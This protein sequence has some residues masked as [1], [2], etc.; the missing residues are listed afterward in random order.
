MQKRDIP[1][2]FDVRPDLC[3]RGRI[4]VEWDRQVFDDNIFANA[5]RLAGSVK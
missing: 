5:A 4:L 2:Y 1:L 3:R